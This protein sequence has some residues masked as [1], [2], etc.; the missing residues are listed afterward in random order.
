MRIEADMEVQGLD[1]IREY[2]VKDITDVIEILPYRSD[3]RYP[4]NSSCYTIMPNGDICFDRTYSINGRDLHT[5]RLIYS[6]KGVMDKPH[7][8]SSAVDISMCSH[9]VRDY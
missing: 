2:I 5:D 3:T 4:N 6:Y 8:D 9:Q 7:Y 1:K